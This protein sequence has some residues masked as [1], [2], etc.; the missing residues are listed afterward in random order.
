MSGRNRCGKEVVDMVGRIFDVRLAACAL[1][2]LGV[3][4]AAPLTAA[5]VELIDKARVEVIKPGIAIQQGSALSATSA[6]I[7]PASRTY[8]VLYWPRT[9]GVAGYNLYRKEESAASYP[10]I[11]INGKKP[12]STVKT[13]AELEAIIPQGS[14]EWQMLSNAFATVDPDNLPQPESP[15]ITI[16]NSPLPPEHQLAPKKVLSPLATIGKIRPDLS[17]LAKGPCVPLDRGLTKTEEALF[18]VMAT[19]NLKIRLARGLG[20]IDN[21]VTAH[22]NYVYELRGVGARGSEVVIAQNVKVQAGHFVLPSPPSSVSAAAGDARVLVLWNRN[23]AAY[24]FAVGRANSPAGTYQ[25]VNDQPVVYD[26][27]EDLDGQPIATPKPGLVDYQRWTEDGLPATHDV[28]TS[29]GTTTVA[30]PANGSTYYYKV[31]SVDILGRQG[32]WSSA[33]SAVT[34]I[35]QTPPRAPEDFSVDASTSPVGL[36]LSWRKVTL[37]IDGHQETDSGQTYNIFRADNL[38]ALE[39][40]DMLTTSSGYFVHNMT[41][42]PTDPASVD[43]SWTDSSPVL[44]QP[45]GEKDFYY[46]VQCVDARGNKGSFSA[47]ISARVP[48]TTPPGPTKVVGADGFADHIRVYWQPNTEPDIGGYQVYV[49]V[50]DKGQPYRPTVG[51]RDEKPLPCDYALV[52]EILNTEAKK[53]LSDTGRIYFDDFSRPSGSPI[54][55]SY[56]IRAFDLSRNV[57]SGVGNNGCPDVNEYVC[58]RLYEEDAPPAPVISALKARNNTVEVDW[59]SSPIQDLRAFHV[60]RSEKENDAP[61]FVGCVFTDGSVS[62]AKWGGMKPKC[63]DIPAEANPTAISGVFKDDKVKPNTIYWY[64]V[65][66]VDWLGNES[67][68]AD[69]RNIPAVSTFTYSKDV[70]SMPVVSPPSGIRSEGCGVT[71]RWTP[72]FDAAAYKGFI[73]FRGSASSGPFRQVSPVLNKNEFVDASALRNVDYWYCVQ[74]MDT[75]GKLSEPSAA[76]LY[77]Y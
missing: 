21:A 4:S 34:P 7:D 14:A 11:P 1:V 30:G 17:L 41:A 39:N 10:Q 23:N 40:V 47:A 45:Y 6:D 24:S 35:D 59:V 20:Y 29:G 64:R 33:S 44:V 69:V 55:Y 77:R 28:V 70:P 3:I 22:T 42:N 63:E 75:A 58:Q 2:I 46:R 73:V 15:P 26:I 18:D 19:A 72:N 65:A 71:V 76:V 57:Y 53:R 13:C 5:P 8:V 52:G 32:S 50:C 25:Q 27:T 37:D 61:V 54:C 68:S 51:N 74:A 31:A 56:W 38:D 62:S 66:A 60:Y 9:E 36:A 48:D 49:G 16:K 43:L 12:I 67:D